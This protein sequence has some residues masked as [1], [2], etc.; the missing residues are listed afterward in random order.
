MSNNPFDDGDDPFG[1]YDEI[2]LPP[3]PVAPQAPVAA[4]PNGGAPAG[5]P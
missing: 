4:A 5:Y 1:S 2:G 3:A